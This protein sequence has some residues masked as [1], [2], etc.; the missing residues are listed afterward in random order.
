M[1]LVLVALVGIV[2]VPRLISMMPMT[3]TNPTSVPTNHSQVFAFISS[4]NLGE[5]TEL[6][7][8]LW[9]RTGPALRFLTSR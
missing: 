9:R 2:H 7:N 6:S 1:V 5:P 3:V 8:F 4:P